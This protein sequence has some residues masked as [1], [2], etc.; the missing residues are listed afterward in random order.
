MKRV[1][2]FVVVMSLCLPMLLPAKKRFTIA[3]YGSYISMGDSSY[4][5]L[6]GGDRLFPSGKITITFLGN[7]YA[8][9]GYGYVPAAYEWTEWSNKGEPEA[10]VGGRRESRKHLIT[11]GLGFYIGYINKASVHLELGACHI[12][13]DIEATWTKIGS[14]QSIKS[15]QS[16]ESGT[17]FVG[18]LGL[19]YGLTKNIYSEFSI[20]FLYAAD[21]RNDERF[22]LG[23]LRLSL[24][25]GITF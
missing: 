1:L 5:T 25:L 18:N 13:N 12:N 3:A 4:E 6:Y 20:G 9:G 2:L 15:E 23:G 22:N 7:L 10:D 19:T 14:N 16:K 8:W 21:K 17:G 11:G 24:G